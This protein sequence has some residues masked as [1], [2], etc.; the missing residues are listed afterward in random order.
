MRRIGVGTHEVD[1]IPARLVIERSAERRHHLAD[2]V[3]DPPE[4][5]AVAVTVDVIGGEIRWLDPEKSAGRSIAAT[6]PS[7]ARGAMGRE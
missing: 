4:E 7:V 3:A 5:V 1:H 6:L 2:A